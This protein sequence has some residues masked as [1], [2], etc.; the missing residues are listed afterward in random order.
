MEFI[1]HQA[2]V[3][4]GITRD[5]VAAFLRTQIS[6]QLTRKTTTKSNPLKRPRA[7]RQIWAVDLIDLSNIVGR[8]N[9]G[10]NYIMTVVDVF[11][12]Q[13]W[14]RSLATKTAAEV[15][16]AYE[17]ISDEEFRPATL[18]LDNGKE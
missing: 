7:A 2:A 18:Q 14:L 15:G 17:T 10:R 4:I 13:V 3:W 6:Y 12:R 11:T 8:G 16:A 1:R 5:Q 9:Q